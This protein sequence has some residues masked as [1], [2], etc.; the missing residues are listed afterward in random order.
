MVHIIPPR[1]PLTDDVVTLRLPCLETGDG[2][3]AVRYSSEDGQLDDGWLPLIPG[4]SPEASVKDWLEGWAG[5]PSHNGPMLVVTIPEAADFIGIVGFAERED[6]RVEMIYGIAP[7][8]RGRGFA[9]RAARLGARWALDL[10]GVA[11]VELRIG[12]GAG[13]S[14]RVARNAGFRP[15]GIVSQYVPGTGDTFEDL[16]F[17]LKK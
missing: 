17:I 14:R 1:E 4:A 2:D 7:R 9:S 8:W 16:R 10:P 3:A 11:A 13:A 12:Q 6:D 5:R 15:A